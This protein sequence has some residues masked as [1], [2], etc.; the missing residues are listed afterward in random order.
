MSSLP[1]IRQSPTDKDFVQNPYPYYA[2]W[3]ALGDFVFWEDFAKPMATAHEAVRAVMTSKSLGRE[4]PKEH[5]VPVRAGLEPFNALE[6]HSMLELE[7][8]RHTRLRGLVLRAFTRNRILYLAPDVSQIADALISEFP[9]GEFDLLSHFAQK[10]PVVV[11]ARLLGVPEETAPHLLAW[12]NA[13]VSMY[14]ARKTPEIEDAAARAAGEFTAFMRNHIEARRSTPGD[15][16]MSLLI[17]AE[18][19]G[20]RLSLDEMVSP[21]ILLLTAGHEATVHSI[22][23]AVRYLADYDDR[24][25]ALEPE[26]IERTVE[27]CLRFDPPLHMFTRHVY[28][29]IVLRDHAFKRGEEIGCLLGS[30]C[31]DAA[32]WPDG[33][34]FHPFRDVRSHAAFGAGSLFCVGAPLARLELQIALPI[35]FAR[36]PNLRVTERPRVANLYHFRGLERLKVSN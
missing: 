3:R 30:A 29:D 1:R 9:N 26:Q 15:D 34:N 19:E 12:S 10:L 33:K 13:M 23:N 4:V 2:E 8:P 25:T 7:P 31:H 6:A 36:C 24:Q 32:V 35:L 16:L 20:D 22:G 14:Q 27:E 21:C 18:S 17:A 28:E 11:I 5:Q